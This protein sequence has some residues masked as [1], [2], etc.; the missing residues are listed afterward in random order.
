MIRRVKKRA[1]WNV[2]VTESKEMVTT[3]GATVQVWDESTTRSYGRNTTTRQREI[4][5]K[6]LAEVDAV[7]LQN[8]ATIQEKLDVLDEVDVEMEKKL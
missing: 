4:F 7:A 1:E 2:E 3:D 5:T 6:A 8:K